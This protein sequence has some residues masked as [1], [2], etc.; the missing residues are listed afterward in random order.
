MFSVTDEW[1]AAY[2]DAHV[3]VLSMSDVENPQTAPELDEKKRELEQDL[4]TVFQD[5]S[6]IKESEIV[7]AYTAYYKRF[8]KSYHVLQQLESVALKGKSIP[9]QAALVEAM[10]MAELQNMLLTAGHDRDR[11]A[12]P[13]RVGVAT[14]DET[15]IR[16]NGAEQ[17]LKAGDMFI[18]DQEGII[19]SIIY[20]P[21]K[22]TAMQPATRNVVFTAYGVPGIGAQ[23][24]RQHMEGLE[25][26]VRIV[27]PNATTDLLEVY[28]AD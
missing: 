10:F 20:G 1:K 17:E 11:L 14:G 25:R 16:M 8:K 9:G 4:R 21:D 5:K 6:Q 22:R 18:A 3:G 2:P 13:L 12:P 26:Y 24:V 7:K 19:S 15:Y 23:P 27:S 28:G